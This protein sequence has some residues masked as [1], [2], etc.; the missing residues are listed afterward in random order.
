MRS[1][2]TLLNGSGARCNQT[3]EEDSGKEGRCEEGGQQE[4]DARDNGKKR[5]EC[6]D[7]ERKASAPM[8]VDHDY[9]HQ[10]NFRKYIDGIEQR[11]CSRTTAMQFRHK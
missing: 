7:A 3:D 5:G 8:S 2:V 1:M 4:D 6:D 9:R 10:P 11:G